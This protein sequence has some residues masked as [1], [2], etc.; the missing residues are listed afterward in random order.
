M[1]TQLA[2]ALHMHV[3]LKLLLRVLELEVPPSLMPFA[4]WIAVWL[5]KLQMLIYL[6]SAAELSQEY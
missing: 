3:A 6:I 2:A 4:Y 1:L 5:E